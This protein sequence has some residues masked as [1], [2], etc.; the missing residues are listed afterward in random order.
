MK[1]ILLAS[2]GKLASGIQS[3][4]QIL[5]GREEEI[6]VIDAYIDDSDFTEEITQFIENVPETEQVVIFTDLYGGSVNQ[7]VM[8]AVANETKKNIQVITGMN[9]PIVLSVLLETEALTSERL[10]ELLT[11]SQVKLVSC[12][13]EAEPENAFFE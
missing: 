3:S 6:A 11:E 7:K 4:I 1:R 10:E 13:I 12:V 8:V 2:H 5:T 9:L